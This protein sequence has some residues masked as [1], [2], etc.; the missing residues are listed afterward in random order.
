MTAAGAPHPR[1][2]QAT[3][4]GWGARLGSAAV[5][6]GAGGVLAVARTLDP[7]PIGHGTHL[8]LGLPP[9]TFFAITGVPCPLCGATTTFSL[10]AHGRLGEGLVNQPFAA[11]LFAMTVLVA[12][13]AWLEAAAPRGRWRRVE[14]VV[15]RADPWAPGVF[16]FLMML[17]WAY[18]IAQA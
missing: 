16:I 15:E 18:K 13:V 7:S 10:L 4:E 8:Q 17:G 1:G 5:G 6:L 14:A 11:L 3:P 2:A 12:S 9:C